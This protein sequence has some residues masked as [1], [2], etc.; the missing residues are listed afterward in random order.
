[1]DTGL[2]ALM[3]TLLWFGLVRRYVNERMMPPEALR[4]MDH[5]RSDR[6]RSNDNMPDDVKP[7]R[8]WF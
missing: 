4:Y 1:V 3:I 5:K 8:R 2:E 7:K 6:E